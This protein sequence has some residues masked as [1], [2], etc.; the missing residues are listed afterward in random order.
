[1]YYLGYFKFTCMK[2]VVHIDIYYDDVENKKRYKITEVNN[3]NTIALRGLF[4]LKEELLQH[5]NIPVDTVIDAHCISN[6]YE[7]CKYMISNKSKQHQQIETRNTFKSAL[8]FITHIDNNFGAATLEKREQLL[9]DKVTSI[10]QK[11]LRSVHHTLNDLDERVI[12]TNKDV[13]EVKQELT[14]IVEKQQ[15]SNNNDYC[16]LLMMGDVE[17]HSVQ[18]INT[19]HNVIEY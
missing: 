9:I 11:H 1:M 7:C 10:I 4:V 14:K 12:Q 3:G 15:T 16:D 18:P 8:Q 6:V 13:M 5:T 2:R 19:T 17:C